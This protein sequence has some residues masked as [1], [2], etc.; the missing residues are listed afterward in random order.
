MR[1]KLRLQPVDCCCGCRATLNDVQLRLWWP[2]KRLY[3]AKLDQ[4]AHFLLYPSGVCIIPAAG[5][6][7]EADFSLWAVS[8]VV[9]CHGS[10]APVL[11][12]SRLCI[13]L[14]KRMSINRQLHLVIH[15]F[16][17]MPEPSRSLQ[18]S[19]LNEMPVTRS[20][21]Q[22]SGP[23]RGSRGR[24][25]GRPDPLPRPSTPIPHAGPSR[26]PANTLN[27]SADPSPHPQDRLDPHIS[28]ERLIEI[29]LEDTSYY[30]IQ[31]NPVSVRIFKP[32]GGRG[33]V[34]CSCDEFRTTQTPCG[35][36]KVCRPCVVQQP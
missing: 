14:Y 18:I 4:I 13:A 7:S 1:L 6:S 25:R 8:L 11:P 5:S 9:L 23:G 12:D 20:H 35:H 30:A 28:V 27:L 29:S 24:S 15:K 32:S 3:W 10:L 36:I 34:T 16:H 31:L 33:R 21:S 26:R 22:P 17:A 19:N 2:G